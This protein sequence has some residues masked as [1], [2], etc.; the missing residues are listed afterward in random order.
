MTITTTTLTRTAAVSAVAGGLLFLTVQINHPYLDPTFTTTGEFAI[1]Q[2]MKIAF[3]V[4]SLVG[5]TGV[6]L[7]Q[8]KQSGVLG[9]L[10]YLLL[11]AAFL[12]M[13]SVEVMGLVALPILARSDPHYV[14]DVLAVG[15]GGT[16]TGDVGLFTVLNTSAG[17]ALVSGGLLFGIAVFRAHVITRWPAAL[18]AV[19]VVATLAIHVLPQVNERLFAVPIGVA[20]VGLGVALWR[21]QLSHTTHPSAGFKNSRLDTAGLK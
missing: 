10:G 1:R 20:L 18:F 16:A 14:S 7:R 15:N 5:I 8:V 17:L 21:E 3:A 2:T 13:A 6:Y 19:A 11:G 9:L 4:L 12:A